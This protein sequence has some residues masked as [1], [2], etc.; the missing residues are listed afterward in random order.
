MFRKIDVFFQF[1]SGIQKKWLSTGKLR[2]KIGILGYI[3][4]YM[5]MYIYIYIY[6]YVC[7][8]ILSYID[9]I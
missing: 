2:N 1:F 7:V 8:R 9:M 4:I 5:C 6:V 3:Y